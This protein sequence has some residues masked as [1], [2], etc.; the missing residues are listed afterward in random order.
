MKNFD[1]LNLVTAISSLFAG[2]LWLISSLVRF[3]T[4]NGISMRDMANTMIT[5]SK[6]SAWAAIS[7]TCAALSQSVIFFLK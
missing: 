6:I 5:Q 3:A 4:K 1:V 2:I 7:A